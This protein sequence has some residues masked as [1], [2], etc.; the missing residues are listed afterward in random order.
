MEL[1][2]G[3]FFARMDQDDISHP[4]RLA[5]QLEHLHAH[6]DHGLCGSAVQVVSGVSRQGVWRYPR[7][8][9]HVRASLMFGSPC[10]HPTLL[11]RREIFDA[12]HRY[13]S[14]YEL[15][16]DWDF[17]DRVSQKWPI[18]N[19]SDRLLDYRL[20]PGGTGRAR[21][22]QQRE[23]KKKVA[24]RILARAG[25]PADENSLQLH[26]EVT[27]PRKRDTDELSRISKHLC[28]TW[29]AASHQGVVPRFLAWEILWRWMQLC[30]ANG[31]GAW[32]KAVLECPIP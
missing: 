17:L 28:R 2:R 27:N 14:E 16:E 22:S 6:C 21:A 1:A 7:D 25:I 5:R 29:R 18:S 4:Q 13:D 31:P 12:G 15:A 19:L 24:A 10:A 32:K 26:L 8:P 9:E 11:L 23:A 3:R 20:S 30:R